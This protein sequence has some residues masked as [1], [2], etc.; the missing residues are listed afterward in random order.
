MDTEEQ[1]TDG[2]VPE[3]WEAVEVVS[4]DEFNG[5][6][7]GEEEV[8]LDENGDRIETEEEEPTSRR[9]QSATQDQPDA[10]RFRR[11]RDEAR[12]EADR[13]R[14]QVNTNQN[15]D[16]WVQ[17]KA[18]VKQKYNEAKARIF[19]LSNNA[20]EPN[21]FINDEIERLNDWKDMEL[22]KE[23]QVREN[24]YM[25]EIVKLR[26]PEY[27]AK[28]GADY[29]L[30]AADVKRIAAAGTPAKMEAMAEAL[31]DIARDNAKVASNNKKAAQFSRNSVSTSGGSRGS[32]RKVKAGSDE[33][34]ALLLAGAVER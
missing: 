10:D 9:R 23:F 15:K 7:D 22:E 14:Q 26:L 31:Y 2:D 8:L 32:V 29:G 5:E 30:K 12:A 33:H 16:A 1:F 34:L 25:G 20:N 13:L 17:R 19:E 3:G 27:A 4:A 11:E 6:T 28:L 24:A 18:V 21:N